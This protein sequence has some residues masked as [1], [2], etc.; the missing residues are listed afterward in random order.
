MTHPASTAVISELRSAPEVRYPQVE[1]R[2]NL[3]PEA[4]HEEYVTPGR[5]V[6]L[7]G[8]QR[9]W[10]AAKAWNLESM[11]ARVGH[12][13]VR[14]KHGYVASKQQFEMTVSEY[15]DL[16]EGKA[17]PPGPP[18]SPLPYLHDL[19]LLAMLPELRLDLE[20]FPRELFPPL[21]REKWWEFSQFFLGAKGSLTPLHF[22]CLETQNLF[23]QVTGHKR[24]ILIPREDAK[25]CSIYDW[26]WSK[27]DPERPDFAK[28]PDFANARPV[29]LTLGPGDTLYLPPGTLHHVRGQSI[30]IS[31]NLDWHT[32]ASALR[33]VA[34]IGRGM[35]L[36]NVR[37]NLAVALALWGRLPAKVLMP[38][39]KSY[40]NYV[41]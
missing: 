9:D 5:P 6:V 33:G 18:G 10:P 24:W 12:Q 3:S 40:L 31:F 25:F 8:L 11:R 1:R 30:S 35:P 27:V 41:S 29:E 26:R 28:Y 14:V 23:F 32:K 20:P 36:K 16:I 38:F 21:Y 22:D 7:E 2:S 13:R 15:L 17:Q 39:Y 34:A 37:Y 4:F 19:P